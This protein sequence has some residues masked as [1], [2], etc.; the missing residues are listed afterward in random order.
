MWTQGVND[1]GEEYEEY[2]YVFDRINTG[3]LSTYHRLDLAVDYKIERPKWN[4]KL[5]L[6]VIN[7]YNRT[8]LFDKDFVIFSPDI[9]AGEEG[10]EE[11]ELDRRL[12][13]FTPNIYFQLEF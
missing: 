2:T 5:G 12:L 6:S 4:M 9:E 8:N 7:M 1:E 10:P 11:I 3:R 13:P